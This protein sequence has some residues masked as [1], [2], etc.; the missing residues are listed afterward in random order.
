MFLNINNIKNTYKRLY[1][2]ENTWGGL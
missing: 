2:L 1:H